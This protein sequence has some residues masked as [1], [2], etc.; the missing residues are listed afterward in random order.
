MSRKDGRFIGEDQQ[1]VVNGVQYLSIRSAPQI[2]S[3][4]AL[5]EERVTAEDLWLRTSKVK[6]EA[7]G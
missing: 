1:P 6:R 7:A 3:A 2:R 4:D 5:L